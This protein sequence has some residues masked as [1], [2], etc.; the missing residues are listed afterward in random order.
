MANDTI[1]LHLPEGLHRRLERLAALTGQPL[2]GL[3][4]QTLSSSIPPLPD[5]LSADTRDALQAMETMSTDELWQL[6]KATIAEDQYGR[7]AWL[8]EQRRE[9]TITGN[10]QTELDQLLQSADLLTLKKAYAAVL[11]KWRGQRLPPLPEMDHVA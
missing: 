10:E 2:E 9:G 3:I 7:L 1:T 4:V 5:D 6:T 8:R 11:L